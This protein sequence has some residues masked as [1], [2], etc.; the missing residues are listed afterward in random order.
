[1]VLRR[2]KKF[3]NKQKCTGQYQNINENNKE[4]ELSVNNLLTLFFQVVVFFLMPQCGSILSGRFLIGIHSTILPK[5]MHYK[6]VNMLDEC[7]WK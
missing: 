3:I 2:Q 1:M 5:Q 7:S 6:C 4:Q